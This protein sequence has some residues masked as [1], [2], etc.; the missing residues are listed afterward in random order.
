M[1]ALNRL[2]L[3]Y[4]SEFD[5]KLILVRQ[6]LPIGNRRFVGN[7]GWRQHEQTFDTLS[8]VN[9]SL[10]GLAL[11]YTYLYRVN[12]KDEPALP[13]PTNITAGAAGQATYFKS[14]SHIM[15]AVYSSI[16]GLR[17][18]GYAFLL[19]LSAPGYAALL[20]QQLATAKLSTAT[21]D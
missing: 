21:I 8:A 16:P 15:D 12:R 20:A 14:N 6:R 18:E 3:T 17:L 1:T 9:T 5:T 7:V 10:E 2:Q 11:S 19:A 4:A 13:V